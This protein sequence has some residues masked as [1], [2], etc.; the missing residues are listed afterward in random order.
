M[1]IDACSYCMADL[2]Q[3]TTNDSSS[4]RPESTNTPHHYSFPST[5]LHTENHW[6]KQRPKQLCNHKGE[7]VSR[8]QSDLKSETRH[9]L[10]LRVKRHTEYPRTRDSDRLRQDGREETSLNSHGTTPDM[11]TLTNWNHPHR[12]ISSPSAS[13]MVQQA[14]DGPAGHKP[15]EEKHIECSRSTPLYCPPVL[16]RVIRA[17][18][19]NLDMQPVSLSPYDIYWFGFTQFH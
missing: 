16:T 11:E 12:S 10:K 19:Q 7:L 8:A 1:G 5:P 6:A 17:P 15:L 13:A 4:A 9:H 14:T 3:G 2:S 18:G